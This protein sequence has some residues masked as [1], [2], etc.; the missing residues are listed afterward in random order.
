M[1]A[2]GRRITPRAAGGVGPASAAAV[3]AARAPTPTARRRAD[4][5]VLR[6]AHA[7]P[8]SAEADRLAASLA[9]AEAC[10]D[11]MLVADVLAEARVSGVALPPRAL[12][13]GV[14][15]LANGGQF[16]RAAAL[17]GELFPLTAGAA[18]VSG[19][20]ASPPSLPEPSTVRAFFLASVQAPLAASE[21]A[22]QRADAARAVLDA[23]V[24]ATDAAADGRDHR[25]DLSHAYNRVVRTYARCPERLVAALELLGRMVA[26]E[27]LECDASTFGA[28][29][30]A[31][32]DAGRAEL[33]EEVLDMRDYL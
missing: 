24:V 8:P 7:A 29:A 32:V 4:R 30:A 21:D 27:A 12:E 33:A 3:A 13:A 17:M 10:D 20:P 2:A 25:S 5:A 9:T 18:G 14:R 22:A 19:P 26:D 16:R 31:C 15:A 11:P 28:V 23:L 1:L 6:R